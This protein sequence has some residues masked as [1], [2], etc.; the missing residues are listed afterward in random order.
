MLFYY[1]YLINELS[2]NKKY[3]FDALINLFIEKYNYI[4]NKDH[5]KVDY[6]I[7]L[8]NKAKKDYVWLLYYAENEEDYMTAINLK[9]NRLKKL[10]PEDKMILEEILQ[11]LSTTKIISK[12]PDSWEEIKKSLF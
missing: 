1:F 6:W 3:S 12:E 10:F 8:E 5:K 2:M 11:K 9:I 7:V 4:E